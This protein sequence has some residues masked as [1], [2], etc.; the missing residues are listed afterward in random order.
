MAF[1]I[2]EQLF[3]TPSWLFEP[4]VVERLT[5]SLP[6]GALLNLQRGM[7]S[8]LLDRSR[9]VRLQGQ[10][11]ALGERRLPRRAVAGRSSGWCLW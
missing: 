11:S 5:P 6:S 10:E 3:K 7:L 8:H 4:A 2:N 1:L 9:L